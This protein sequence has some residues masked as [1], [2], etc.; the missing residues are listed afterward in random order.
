MSVDEQK[1]SG[2]EICSSWATTDYVLS[3]VPTQTWFW[4]SKYD[5]EEVELDAARD[6]S[7]VLQ[8]VSRK[9]LG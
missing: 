7:G 5:Q 8:S 9:T 3:R 2:A 4:H 1:V 6:T